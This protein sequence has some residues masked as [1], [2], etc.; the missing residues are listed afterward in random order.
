MRLWPS[1]QNLVVNILKTNL[2]HR[3]TPKHAQ[4]VHVS[5]PS[6]FTDQDFWVK[7]K[8]MVYLGIYKWCSIETSTSILDK[9][10]WMMTWLLK[11]W[12]QQHK[13]IPVCKIH[14]GHVTKMMAPSINFVMGNLWCK[15]QLHTM[16]GSWDS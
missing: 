9:R 3:I 6:Q 12:W 4:C 15:F 1:E 13:S 2:L 8:N 16:C 7:I 10:S 11:F 5:G 14:L